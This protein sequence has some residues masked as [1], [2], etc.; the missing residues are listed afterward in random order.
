MSIP[1]GPAAVRSRLPF[2]ASLLRR[3]AALVAGAA[4]VALGLA[5]RLYRLGA[6]SLWLDEGGTW[7]EVTG[8]TGKG[9]LALLGELFSPDAAYPLYHVLLKAWL[10]LAGDAEWALRFPSALAGAA[11]VLVI[12]IVALEL[13]L[14][15][16][17]DERR[18]TNDKGASEGRGSWSED[19]RTIADRVLISTSLGP[20]S[21]VLGPAI[22]ALLLATS[23]FA[24]W[25]SQDAK[26]YSLLMLCAA[27]LVWALLRALRGG[28]RRDWL[29]LLV[30]ALASLF[31]HRLALLALAG[32]LVALALAW[33]F[34]GARRRM[35][36][37][38]WGLALVAL[39]CAGAAI[40]GAVR[41]VG[42]ESR[43]G[44][45]HIPAGPASGLWLSLAHF[46]LDRGNIGGWLGV[47]LLAWALPALALTAWGLALLARDARRGDVAALGLLCM[48][49]VPLGLFAAALGFAQLFESRYATVAFPAWVL[50]IGYPLVGQR[51]KDQGRK[52]KDEGPNSGL[53]ELARRSS[54]VGRWSLAA[55]VLVVNALVLFQPQHG[56]LSGAPVKE[57]W[58]EGVAEIAR[59]A[60]PDD[61]I[62]LHPYYVQPLWDYYAPRVTPD[63]LPKIVTFDLLG[64]GYCLD[65]ARQ[66][67]SVIPVECYRRA[68][69]EA[70]D[71]AAYGRKRMLMLLAPDH[72]R[73]IDPPKKLAQ[74]L[75]EYQAGHR[76]GDQPPNADDRYGFL[77]LRFQFASDQRTW[78]C[79]GTSDA[80]IGVEVMCASFPSFYH[81]TGATAIPEP[82]IALGA[83]FGGELRLRGYSLDL[84][85]GA[86]RP[87]GALPVTLYW[88]A[89]A[90]PTR[91]YRMFLHLCRDCDI[92]P[93]ANADGAPLDGYPP[94][95]RTTTWIVGDPVHDERSL[96][97]PADLPPGRYTLLLGVYPE[98]DPSAGA[99]LAALSGDARVIGGTRLALGEVTIARQ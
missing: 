18:K 58:R 27:L 71:R 95:G 33:P 32:A 8:R 72:A 57:Q 43:G 2:F 83:T 5:L 37:A 30:V 66:D 11:A 28:S 20:W 26:V 94:A 48:L 80:L 13:S 92:P 96:R 12:Y 46:A 39:L 6:Q 79:G 62:I 91:D 4:V 23:P 98:G 89:M 88:D 59:R 97:L 82:R 31:V 44:T 17:K 40:Y 22:A 64:Q 81:Q 73:T 52:T 61:L 25:Q 76:P 35:A 74:R 93:L 54:V 10:A 38:R 67:S 55:A 34:G 49:L 84:L 99:R 77:G 45:G 75:A 63:P 69:E 85:G 86:A 65:A 50:T 68:Y 24:L 60:H 15:T 56:L 3:H 21:F 51:T 41:A 87:G 7:A 1:A 29:A 16:T 53:F 14:P 47:P 78:P 70:F 42:A 9:W 36:L 19:R 90:K